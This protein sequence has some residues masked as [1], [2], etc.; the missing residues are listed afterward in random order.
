MN[1]AEMALAGLRGETSMDWLDWIADWAESAET[2]YD[3]TRYRFMDGSELL[4]ERSGDW[5]VMD[6]RGR[7]VR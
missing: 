3:G 2:A 5:F 6:E 7:W 4:H 1:T